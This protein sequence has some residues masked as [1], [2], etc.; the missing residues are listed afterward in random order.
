M[1]VIFCYFNKGR[2]FDFVLKEFDI[3]IVE[4]DL[5]VGGVYVGDDS[6]VGVD[7]RVDCGVDVGFMVQLNVGL[8]IVV[9]IEDFQGM[10]SEDCLS[11][12]VD[13]TEDF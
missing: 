13:D 7:N 10:D 11:I 6:R 5:L 8:T 12:T 4:F 3:I 1:K 2:G 9:Y